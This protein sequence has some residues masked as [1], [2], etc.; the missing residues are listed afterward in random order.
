MSCML[1]E[2]IS[3]KDYLYL[4]ESSHYETIFKQNPFDRRFAP[5]LA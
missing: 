4:K 5:E 1:N 3:K 2:K